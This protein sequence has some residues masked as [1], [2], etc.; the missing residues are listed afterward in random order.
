MVLPPHVTV[1]KALAKVIQRYSSTKQRRRDMNHPTYSGGDAMVGPALITRKLDLLKALSLVPLGPV[2][3]GSRRILAHEFDLLGSGWVQVKHGMKCLGLEGI[4]FEPSEAVTADSEGRWLQGR[5]NDANLTESARI[6]KLIFLEQFKIQDSKFKIDYVPIDWQLDFKSGYRWSEKNL[7]V[8]ITFGQVPGQDVKVPWELARMQHLPA[9]AWAFGMS[10]QKTQGFEVPEVYLR[11]FRNQLLDFI[12][13]NPPRYGVNWSCT[14]DVAIRVANWVLAYDLFRS[15]GAKF[16]VEFDGL[17]ARSVAEHADHIFHHLEWDPLLRSNHY[18]ADIVGLLW[19][20]AHLPENKESDRWSTFVMEELNKEVLSQ[21]D[22][23]G[24]NFEASTSYH[25]LSA[26]MIAY[27]T[28]LLVGLQI[29]GGRWDDFWKHFSEDYWVRFGR[30]PRFTMDMTQSSGQVV[31]IGDNDSGRFFK[32]FPDGGNLLNHR[33]LAAAFNGLLNQKEFSEFAKGYEAEA[34]VVFQLAQKEEIIDKGNTS[35]RKAGGYE[36]FGLYRINKRGLDL[37]VR[38]GPVGQKGNGG[39]AHNDQLSFELAVMGVSLIV[40]PGTYVYTPLPEQR[41]LFRS[42]AMH[43]TMVVDGMEQNT[44]EPGAAGLFRMTDRSKA[45]VI[46]F[47]N[48]A[49]IGEHMGFGPVTRRTLNL[50]EGRLEGLDE[51]DHPGQKAIYFHLAPGSQVHLYPP[52]EAKVSLGKAY[53]RFSSQDGRWEQEPGYYSKAY[54]E[55]EPAPVLVLK[56]SAKSVS[57]KIQ[58]LE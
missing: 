21:F 57:W 49:F 50:K 58:I 11:E 30:M 44:W 29:F 47:D 48:R 17:L 56:S 23:D 51:C 33:H 8:D 2:L 38:C 31:Q 37:L 42:T 5:I 14:M 25:R 35:V 46:Q 15:L 27:S 53:V 18:L 13:S 52:A 26:E 45:K 10:Q 19:A 6:W 24:A 39:H 40:D 20:T 16:D 9:L 1:Q 43:N 34:E 28:A 3:A 22:E 41:N 4:R 12:A 32:L 54:G 55:K 36:A 7:S